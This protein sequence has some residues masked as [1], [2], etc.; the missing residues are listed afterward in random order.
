[1]KSGVTQSS[2]LPS[3]FTPQLI[4]RLLVGEG[5]H[6]SSKTFSLKSLRIPEKNPI[7]KWCPERKYSGISSREF[8]LF[9]FLFCWFETD[10]FL[11]LLIWLWWYRKR[12][13][14]LETR[15]KW[16]GLSEG[17]KKKKKKTSTSSLFLSDPFSDNESV[18]RKRRRRTKTKQKLFVFHFQT[19]TMPPNSLSFLLLICALLI[20]PIQSRGFFG[21]PGKSSEFF[22]WLGAEAQWRSR[23]KRRLMDDSLI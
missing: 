18:Q 1:M 16:A 5:Y 9:L 13:R 15:K 2:F 20:T 22:G 21:I 17:K 19:G 8:N 14:E 7:K 23:P 12:E 10:V 6:N 11:S 4:Q 3:S